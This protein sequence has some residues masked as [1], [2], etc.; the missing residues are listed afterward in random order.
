M[1]T[2]VSPG[3]SV[4]ITDESFYGSSGPGTIPLIVLATATNKPHP[5]GIGI[6]E[7]TAPDQANRLFLATSQ[8][9]LIQTYGNPDFKNIQGTPVHGHEL[10]EYG[11]HAA[12]QYLGIN[13]RAYVMR[14]DIDLAQLESSVEE[15]KG[16][17]EAGTVWLDLN[18]SVFGVFQIIKDSDAEQ[19]DPFTKQ[20]LL[21]INDKEMVSLEDGT[22]RTEYG[23]D[24]EFAIVT[25]F[26][27]FV[28]YE[29]IAGDWFVVGSENWVIERSTVKGEFIQQQSMQNAAAQSGSPNLK[30]FVNKYVFDIDTSKSLTPTE[31]ANRLNAQIAGT[32]GGVY[33]SPSPL[34]GR[35]FFSENGGGIKINFTLDVL[36]L[37]GTA[38]HFLDLKPGDY[39]RAKLTM[40]PHN[41]VPKDSREGDVWVKTTPTNGGSSFSFKVFDDQEGEFVKT[42]APMFSSDSKALVGMQG[43]QEGSIYVQFGVDSNGEFQTASFAPRRWGGST[44]TDLTYECSFE[45][46]FTTP[47]PGTLWFNPDFRADIMVADGD[48]W[49]G[50]RVRYPETDPNGPIL[51]GS[52]PL[53]QSDGTPLVT[54]DLW[55]DTSDTENYPKIFRYN[56]STRKWTLIN[57]ADQSTPYGIVFRDARAKS[58]PEYDGIRAS[59]SQSGYSF[60]SDEMVD[61]TRSCYVDPDCVDPRLY[62]AGTL[63]F[64]TRYSTNNVKQWIP[65]W[66]EA[67]DDDQSFFDNNADFTMRTYTIGG[68]TYGV[69]DE[70][71]EIEFPPVQNPGRW[72]TASGNQVDGSPYMGRKAQRQMIVKALSATVAGNSDLRSELVYFNL[73]AAP[74]YPELIDEMVTLNTD[75]KEVAFIVGDTPARLKPL[76]S[77]I[78]NWASNANNAPSNG[79]KGLTTGNVYVGLYYPWGLSTNVDGSEIMVPPS[80]VALR[81]IAY[82]DNM[83]YPWFAPAGF[84][85]G[86]VTN[87]ASVGYLNDEGEYEPVILN[88]GQRDVLYLN[89]INPIAYIPNRGLV[90]YGQKTLSPVTSARDRVNVARL[91]NYLRYNLDI[92]A[93]PFLFEPNDAYTRNAFKVTLERFMSGLVTLRG[94]DDFAVVCD[95]TNNTPDRVDRN[96]LW[97]DI[98]IQPTKS[99]EFIHLPIRIRN[100][101]STLDL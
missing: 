42:S 49:L 101:G 77:A 59:G 99:V 17:P 44:W 58:G 8:R 2:L 32:A 12:Y 68:G 21:I 93:K 29:K 75:K 96:E 76:G 47:E 54:N 30:I 13:N 82:S 40:Q 16:K 43:L 66:F 89:K 90:V 36:T 53:T 88:Q 72:V 19:M 81:T 70:V 79:D 18:E 6:A 83:S 7:G 11:L 91:E 61:M 62:M 33:N 56:A 28:L 39:K 34:N 25:C 85:R 55:I 97:A 20:P 26:E 3:V 48:E 98:L 57:N 14:A 52:K 51:A 50:Y 60:N 80:T 31:I 87:A 23:E 94:L 1:A 74:G 27:P 100:S 22:P 78:Q 65:T 71:K 84:N 95:A 37:E 64:N 5:S 35:V 9:E 73:I 45:P 67:G 41:L 46:P 15:P 63:L 86:M 4:T 24:G 38:L 10:N 92:I 69:G